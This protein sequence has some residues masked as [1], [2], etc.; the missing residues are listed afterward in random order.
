M[1][2]T[3]VG[4]G[5]FNIGYCNALDLSKRKTVLETFPKSDPLTPVIDE[6]S[7]VKG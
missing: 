5:S 3:V 7:N 2:V 6:T 1:I 4:R